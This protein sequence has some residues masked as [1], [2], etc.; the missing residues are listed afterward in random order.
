MNGAPATLAISI[1]FR[2]IDAS[3]FPRSEWQLVGCVFR[4]DAVMC[5]LEVAYGE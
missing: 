3:G 1:G 5:N 2:S 4:L